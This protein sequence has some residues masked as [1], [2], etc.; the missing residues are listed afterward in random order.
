MIPRRHFIEPVKPLKLIETN[1]EIH[2]FSWYWIKGFGKHSI[3]ALVACLKAL[4]ITNNLMSISNLNTWPDEVKIKSS[5]HYSHVTDACCSARVA[6]LNALPGKNDDLGDLA[7]NPGGSGQRRERSACLWASPVSLLSGNRAQ[8]HTDILCHSSSRDPA[9]KGS[10]TVWDFNSSVSSRG[11]R[12]AGLQSVTEQTRRK[13]RTA[14]ETRYWNER[15]EK[16]HFWWFLLNMTAALV[17]HYLEY[18]VLCLFF[19]LMLTSSLQSS[20]LLA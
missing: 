9:H 18:Q 20:T 17:H 1:K 16:S 5:A 10:F 15:Q 19:V 2:S 12:E 13:S 11:E 4:R 14:A 8:T 7:P 6:T 3:E